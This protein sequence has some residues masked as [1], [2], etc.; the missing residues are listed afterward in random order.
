[1]NENLHIYKC[2]RGIKESTPISQYDFS[3]EKRLL[4]PCTDGKKIGF[5]N[6]KGQLVV[7]PKYDGWEG[8]CWKENHSIVVLRKT[9]VTHKGKKGRLQ[10]QPDVLRGAINH[11]GEEA[12][13][14]EYL[15]VLPSLSSYYIFTVENQDKHFAVITSYGDVVV[16][17]GKYYRISGF[18]KGFAKVCTYNAETGKYKFGIID[19]QGDVVLPLEWDR[20]RSF[21]KKNFSEIRVSRKE[22]EKVTEKFI[23]I[24]DLSRIE[25]TNI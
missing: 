10:E 1:M 19:E 24:K 25:G 23:K 5:V 11:L 14:L 21:Y 12:V 8:N 17:Y 9:V 13:P 18:D 22:D 7:S 16:P 6:R 15:S 4:I 2:T 20:M 3:T